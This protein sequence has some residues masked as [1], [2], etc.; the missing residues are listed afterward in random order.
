MIS[1]F[2]TGKGKEKRPPKS[3]K[4]AVDLQGDMAGRELDRVAQGN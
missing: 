2:Q 3:A 4:V 1:F